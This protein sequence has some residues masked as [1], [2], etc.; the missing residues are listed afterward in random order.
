LLQLVNN[1]R[2]CLALLPLYRSF[3][4]IP[5]PEP[6]G[7]LGVMID[8]LSRYPI[9]PEEISVIKVGNQDSAFIVRDHADIAGHSVVVKPR[10]VVFGK[11]NLNPPPKKIKNLVDPEST[12]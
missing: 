6:F 12:G 1:L 10:R 7:F 9:D 4:F 3:L 8:I 11:R 5:S 2:V